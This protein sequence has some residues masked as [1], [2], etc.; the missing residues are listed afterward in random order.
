M[1]NPRARAD[2]KLLSKYVDEDGSGD[3]SFSEF[4]LVRETTITPANSRQTET[5]TFALRNTSL[6]MIFMVVVSA[7]PKV[8]AIVEEEAKL[9]QNDEN[10]RATCRKSYFVE[11]VSGIFSSR[12]RD[13]FARSSFIFSEPAGQALALVLEIDSRLLSGLTAVLFE[14]DRVKKLKRTAIR[15]NLPSFESL[16]NIKRHPK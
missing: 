16:K 5:V 4:V 3:V 15:D 9:D 14:H 8:S 12:I 2:M 11:T 10:H 1:N 7:L 6:R 13:I